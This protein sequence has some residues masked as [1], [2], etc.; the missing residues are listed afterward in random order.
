MTKYYPIRI[1]CNILLLCCGLFL[2][3]RQI[4]A[5]SILGKDLL[6]NPA[7]Q[8]YLEVEPNN[9]TAYIEE[10]YPFAEIFRSFYNTVNLT[11]EIVDI[12]ISGQNDPYNE[13]LRRPDKDLDYDAFQFRAVADGYI[14]ITMYEGNFEAMRL[15]KYVQ[16]LSQNVTAWSRIPVATLLPPDSFF[17]TD[18]RFGS[19][20]TTSKTINYMAKK[21]EQYKIIVFPKGPYKVNI[22]SRAWGESKKTFD[23]TSADT[24]L[25]FS[26]W[27]YH[28]WPWVFSAA[29]N[30]WLFYHSSNGG[31]A[32]WRHKEKKW[33]RF[34][35][36]TN[37]WSDLTDHYE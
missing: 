31:W 25:V 9:L 5:D 3:Q 24:T 4:F 33:Y 11:A 19:T 16:G 7:S 15:L 13:F 28:S 20:T 32:V 35:S 14:D 12:D 2:H 6:W 36:T 23:T 18:N 34:N 10:S 1:A 17:L 8:I 30:N 37:T 29:D 26:G 21:G 22:H 27:N